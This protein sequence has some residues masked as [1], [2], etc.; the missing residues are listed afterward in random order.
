M[1]YLLDDKGKRVQNVSAKQQEGLDMANDTLFR[2]IKKRGKSDE[3]ARDIIT[4][5][6]KWF[7][8]EDLQANGLIDRIVDTG[9]KKELAQLEPAKLVAIL[10]SENNNTNFLS[11]KKVIAKLNGFG[12]N[13]T[14]DATE[15]QV[16]AAMDNLPKPA[17]EK[18]AAKLVDTLIAV[19]KKTGAVT[20][21]ET[22][23]EAKFRKLADA[24]MDLFV[25][26]LG[27]DQLTT[28]KAP[29][30]TQARMSDLI[31]DAQKNQPAAASEKDYAWYEKNDP[32]ALAKIEQLE[33]EKFAK[34]Q[35]ADL[36]KYE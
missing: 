7:T 26:M 6:D 22:G 18:P 29:R 14:E 21:G 23:N 19:G 5:N 2:L 28:A 13:L 1:A 15:D 30:G 17:P 35:A 25:D 24:D 32:A 33:P 4:P 10:K 9:R 16:V 34:L 20:E 12:V 11:M 8:P 36:A 3:E 31:A 27:I